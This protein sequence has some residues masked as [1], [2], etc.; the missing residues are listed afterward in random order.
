MQNIAG[1]VRT[2]LYV[3]FSNGPLQMD[4]PVLADQYE[5]TDNISVQ[6]QDV[7]WKTCRER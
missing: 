3:T 2:N 7:V 1:E 6:T 5:P 4:V